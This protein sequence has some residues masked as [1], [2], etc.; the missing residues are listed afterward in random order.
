MLSLYLTFVLMKTYW[1]SL[2]QSYFSFPFTCPDIFW[3]FG[4]LNY[5][6]GFWKW[7]RSCTCFILEKA[8]WCLL[9]IFHL[10]VLL[11]LWNFLCMLCTHYWKNS[12]FLKGWFRWLPIRMHWTKVGPICIW[13]CYSFIGIWRYIEIIVIECICFSGNNFSCQI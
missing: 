13:S 2:W 3:T 5:P 6:P 7:A 11:F 1:Y 10:H 9:G 4:I 8:S 12:L